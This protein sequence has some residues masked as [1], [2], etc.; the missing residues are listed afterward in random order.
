M[1]LKLNLNLPLVTI[2]YQGLDCDPGKRI[3]KCLKQSRSNPLFLQTKK[4]HQ[5]AAKSPQ[6]PLQKLAK[7]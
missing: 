3:Q 6:S 7:S 4:L 1:K 2:I 5:K